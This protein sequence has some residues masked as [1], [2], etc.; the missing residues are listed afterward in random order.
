ME[1]KFRGMVKPSFVPPKALTPRPQDFVAYALHMTAANIVF[2][3]ESY[4]ALK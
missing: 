2:L 3:V 4:K 1:E